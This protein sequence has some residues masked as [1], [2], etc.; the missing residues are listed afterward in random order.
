VRRRQLTPVAQAHH[1]RCDIRAEDDSLSDAATAVANTGLRAAPDAATV[2]VVITT[3]N[4][5]HFL[6]QAIHSVFAQTHPAAEIL[7]VDDGS[8]DDPAAVVSQCAGV[9]LL[10]QNNQGLSAA[11]NAGLKAVRS[12]KVVFL[13]AD[14]R[15]LPNA[16]AAGL[17]CFAGAA[18]CGFVYGGYRLIDRHG[19]AFG[20]DSYNPPG[21][22]PYRDMLRGNQIGMHATVMY[23]RAR[24]VASGGFDTAVR[25]CEDYDVYLRM[26]RDGPIASH[27][28][29]VAEYRWH[30][31]NMSS[32]HREM[33]DWALRVHARH[34][35]TARTLGDAVR[36]WKEGRRVWR[37]HYAGEMLGT[38][39]RRWATSPSLGAV[40]GG[41]LQAIQAAPVATLKLL[42]RSLRNKLALGRF[43]GRR[44][45]RPRPRFP[46]GS[47]RFGDVGDV[48]PI[49]DDFGFERGTPIDR[50]YIEQ[51]LRGNAGDIAG[52][53]L[54]VGDDA[55]SRRFGG[56]RI[57]QQDVLHV[58]A[59]NEAATLVGDL[60]QPATLPA[61]AFDCLVLTQT[62]HL[63]FDMR[64][65]VA[66]MHRGLKPG[67]VVLLTVPG[68]TRIDRGEWGADWFWSLTPA[69]ATR[70]FG[71]VFGAD[72]V[73]VESHGNVF[74]ATAFLQGLAVEE[75]DTAKL[76]I[77]DACF[78]VIVTVRARKP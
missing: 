33:L 71:D 6:L 63:I 32:N 50:F 30:G 64:A 58:S 26:A 20:R 5:A 65:A 43:L 75:T 14:D 45:G 12:D 41:V 56:Q 68:I 38:A 11:R 31:G 37:H 34:E 57:T 13:D 51:F 35:Q 77:N 15:L 67:G 60:S 19:R 23:D 54:E 55:Y 21:A 74:A 2:A 17:A 3:Y 40:A 25:R 7:V 27:P 1:N 61:A 72:N 22:E 46:L 73:R 8:G 44:G 59:D 62:L 78:P 69:A 48:Q 42:L 24:L 16:I 4:H 47:V 18:G 36:D 49:S 39:R 29:L 52:R 76:A 10:R 70:L 66:E 9:T 28:Q 53:V